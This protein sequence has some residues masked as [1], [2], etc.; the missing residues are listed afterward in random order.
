MLKYKFA[1]IGIICSYL[2]ILFFVSLGLPS[3]DDYSATISLIKQYYFDNTGFEGKLSLLFSKHN[4][5]RIFVSRLTA[6][7]Y[8]GL[9]HKINFYHLILFQNI[10]LF[11]FIC[12]IMRLFKREKQFDELTFLFIVIFLCSTSF[13][14]V[15]NFY[16]AGI[17]HFAV[18][19]F[20]FGSL[21]VLDRTVKTWSIHFLL[22]VFLALMAVL[23]FG[24]GFLVLLMGI[25][26]LFAQKKYSI[27]WVWTLISIGLIVYSVF[28][29]RA[30]TALKVA[31][32]PEWMARLLLTFSGSFFFVNSQALRYTNIILC[33]IV[34]VGVLG[35]WV[36]LFVSKYAFKKPLL[37]A[38]FSL[39]I[40]SGIIISIS[41]F[42]TKSAGGIA[43]RYMFFSAVIPV[44]IV[45]I[46]L[47]LN[48][49]KR[50][51]LTYVLPFFT[52]LWAVMFYNNYHGLKEMNEEQM[53]VT[54]DWKRD[55]QKSL[56]YYDQ[57]SATSEILQ[58]AVCNQ[59]I[60]SK[61]Y[62]GACEMADNQ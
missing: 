32:N 49:I 15:S 24:N 33:M 20:S 12:L 19:F 9:F 43:P 23:S 28:V 41:R 39:P 52:L 57:S 11:G 3:F 62:E 48:L 51:N 37:Y 26:L 56:V 6:I 47:D 40:L 44:L 5:H 38:L 22:A 45:L 4:E 54:E 31:F 35:F 10:F 2:Y 34:G 17:Q 13:W 14:Q 53:A 61:I 21:I 29:D 58:W 1:G 30:D 16:W 60:E 55:K 36:W 50:K 46:L 25:F 27:L 18:L 7:I 42:D 8:F 59:I